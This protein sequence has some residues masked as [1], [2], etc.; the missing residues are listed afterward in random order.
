MAI[1]VHT[2]VG[3]LNT[4][5][6]LATSQMKLARSVEKL[7]SGF[8]INKAADDAAGMAISEQMS[9]DIRSLKQASRNANDATSL[10]Q[11]AEGGLVEVANILGR[12]RELAVESASD[13]VNDTQRGFINTEIVQL[14]EEIDRIVDV[15]DYNETA[16]L[17]GT[18]DVDIQIGLDDGDV[19]N[20]AIAQDHDSAG[21]GVDA[22]N[23]DMSTKAGAVSSLQAIDQAI[24]TVSTTRA[25]LG[26]KQN[27]VDH[28][29]N[30]LSIQ[31][32][33]LSAANSR[34]KEVDVAEEMATLT[35][36]QIL[37]QAGVSMLSQ[38]NSSPQVALNLLRG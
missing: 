12:M 33:N 11:T 8:R 38:A 29:V 30:N 26:A 24:E 5:R 32:E 28:I 31:H 13:G 14:Q 23:V 36:N 37:V 15:A 19:L 4:Q 18:M 27:R 21:L 7:S 10:L 9:A 17:D 20:I 1:N 25:T 34:I 6:S 2:N 16:L 35:K 3:S 22:G